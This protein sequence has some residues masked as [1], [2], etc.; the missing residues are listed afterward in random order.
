MSLLEFASLVHAEL[1]D[2]GI[3]A[4][5]GG[6]AAVEIHSDGGYRSDDLDFV[7]AY[8]IAEIDVVLSRL[9]FARERD[10]R[11]SVFTHP[12]VSWYL[13]FPAAPLA[14]GRVTVPMSEC[15]ELHTGTNWLRVITPTHCLMD[16]LA[17]CGHWDDSEALEQAF[18]VSKRTG[19]E[20][21]WS[22]LRAFADAE[23]IAQH[24]FVSRFF[25]AAG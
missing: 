19:S 5:L 21:D 12:R 15:I 3:T 24:P 23:G 2:A 20:V 11:Q 8:P 22:R 14:F 17:A 9:G 25:N 6:G 10:P 16:R 7:T 13:E 1:A 4:V 18:A